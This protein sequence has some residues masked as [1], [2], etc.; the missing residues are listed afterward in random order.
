MQLSEL[1]TSDVYA[2]VIQLRLRTPCW[3]NRCCSNVVKVQ[4][5]V[6]TTYNLQPT[7]YNVHVLCYHNRKLLSSPHLQDMVILRLLSSQLHSGDLCSQKPV[8]LSY[9]RDLPE[10]VIPRPHEPSR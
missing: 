3:E 9:N 10:E 6:L 4:C 5:G 2:P 8:W 7:T 1:D